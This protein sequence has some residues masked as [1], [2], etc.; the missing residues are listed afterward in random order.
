VILRP[1]VRSKREAFDELV[2]LLVQL[3]NLPA[4]LRNVDAHLL[5]LTV[6]LVYDAAAGLKLSIHGEAYVEHPAYESQSDAERNQLGRDADFSDKL[7]R[8]LA[9]EDF[10]VVPPRGRR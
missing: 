5:K 8:E 4:R 10:R 3:A 2:I 1:G 7:S 6:L 9:K